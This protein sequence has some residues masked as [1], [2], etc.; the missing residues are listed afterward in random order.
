MNPV[1]FGFFAGNKPYLIDGAFFRFRGYTSIAGGEIVR[2]IASNKVVFQDAR[3][4]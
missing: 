3:L 4:F 2:Y 1:R